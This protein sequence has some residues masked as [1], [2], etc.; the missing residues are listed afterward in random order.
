MDLP[1]IRGTPRA[2]RIQKDPAHTRLQ[3]RGGGGSGGTGRRLVKERSAIVVQ[4]V[5]GCVTCRK[6]ASPGADGVN[7]DT[8]VNDPGSST[9]RIEQ[10]FFVVDDDPWCI[11]QVAP[12]LCGQVQSSNAGIQAAAI[13]PD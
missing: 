6:D 12:S 1:D 13:A 2:R 9:A 3:A 7:S 11:G 10:V 4:R 5:A 8:S